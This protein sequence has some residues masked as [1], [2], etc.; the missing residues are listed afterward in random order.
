MTAE[1]P[2]MV[3]TTGSFTLQL[4]AEPARFGIVRRIV[5]AYLR[6]WGRP[7]LADAAA[8]C[9]TEM[10]TNVHRHVPLPDCELTLRN[11]AEGVWACVGDTSSALPVITR[12]TWSMECGR[13]MLLLAATADDW[14]VLTKPDG[15]KVVWVLLRDV[16][17]AGR[18]VV[19]Q[20]VAS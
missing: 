17:A 2:P 6:M 1:S 9:V 4:L 7:E 19:G 11:E 13:G 3:T 8:V 15:G 20:G 14:G 5:G 18:G 10:L 12:P 16:R